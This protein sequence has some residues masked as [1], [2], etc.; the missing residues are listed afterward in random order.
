MLK[1]AT[2]GP[3]TSKSCKKPYQSPS[4]VHFSDV[5]QTDVELNLSKGGV[6]QTTKRKRS[7]SNR[8]VKT[9]VIFFPW[10]SIIFVNSM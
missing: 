5:E 4:E 6:T 8:Y 10:R 2:I 9:T 7:T 3:S 1:K